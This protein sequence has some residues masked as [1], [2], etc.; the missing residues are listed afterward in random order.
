V[1]LREARARDVAIEAFGALLAQTCVALCDTNVEVRSAPRSSSKHYRKIATGSNYL[2][3]GS[4]HLVGVDALSAGAVHC[5]R[6]VVVGRGVLHSRVGVTE[7]CDQ[8]RI[9]PKIRTPTQ[10]AA[11]DVVPRHCRGT[12]IPGQRN[13]MHWLRRGCKVHS[14]DV[15][16]VDRGILARWAKC[17]TSVARA[18][19]VRPVCQSGE[20]IIAGAVAGRCGT[21]RSAQGDCCPTPTRGRS[22][23]SRN[24]IRLRGRRG[25]ASILPAYNATAAADEASRNKHAS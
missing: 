20:G 24:A 15:G 5:C 11:V 3:N 18:D 19:G 2:R 8:G 16:T 10:R 13:G 9:D 6:D 14:S 12:R 22:D 17:E 23:C 4:R 7:P 21:R 25:R 1:P